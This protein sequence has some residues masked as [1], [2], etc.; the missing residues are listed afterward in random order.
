VAIAIQILVRMMKFNFDSAFVFDS[1]KII[2]HEEGQRGAG[3]DDDVLAELKTLSAVNRS[4]LTVFDQ[5][6]ISIFRSGIK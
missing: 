2:G 3:V 6:Y 5:F 1:E 4:L